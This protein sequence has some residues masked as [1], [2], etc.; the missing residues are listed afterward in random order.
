MYKLSEVTLRIECEFPLPKATDF[1]DTQLFKTAIIDLQTTILDELNEKA[2]TLNI[3]ETTSYKVFQEFL[4][5][6]LKNSIDAQATT[7]KLMIDVNPDSNR[8]DIFILDNGNVPL[9]EAL[10]GKYDIKRAL[11]SPSL[12]AGQKDLLGGKQLALAMCAYFLKTL[13]N[14]SLTLSSQSSQGVVLQLTSS[15]KECIASQI[16]SAG[17]NYAQEIV[18]WL[19]TKEIDDTHDPAAKKQLAE[20]RDQLM[21]KFHHDGCGIRY[22]GTEPRRLSTLESLAESP[23]SLFARRRASQTAAA[24]PDL[25]GTSTSLTPP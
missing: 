13:D 15:L 22:V 4:Y 7:M 9:P 18:M 17:I 20:E 24:N 11:L 8:L 16:I 19:Y 3:C 10:Q 12:K 5:E 25:T 21:R 14:G 2:V 23:S 1:P 6:I